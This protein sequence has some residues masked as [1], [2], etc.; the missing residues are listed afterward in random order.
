MER[1]KQEKTLEFSI[2]F[3]KGRN[4]RNQ[5]RIG[6][7]PDPVEVPV[8]RVPRI[9]KLLALAIKLDGMIQCGEAKDYAELAALG[10]VSR[11][12]ITQIM[13]LLHLAPDIQ[14]KILYLNPIREGR[15][16]I[17]M[18]HIAPIAKLTCWMEQRTVWRRLAH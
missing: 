1:Q 6:K 14:E 18:K 15:E 4:G 12:R 2:H 8:G 17:R 10:H 9:T 3:Q 16:P 5:L 7:A 11:A 13:N